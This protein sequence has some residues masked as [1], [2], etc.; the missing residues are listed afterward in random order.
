[1]EKIYNEL[2]EV[3][4]TKESYGTLAGSWCQIIFKDN[5]GCWY[6]TPFSDWGDMGCI[7]FAPDGVYNPKNRIS[8]WEY[9]QSDKNVYNTHLARAQEFEI[10]QDC[11][12]LI[13]YLELMKAI[14]INV[15]SDYI[16]EMI[17]AIEGCKN[18]L[19][20]YIVEKDFTDIYFLLGICDT[21]QYDW[22][23]NDLPELY[24]NRRYH[25]LLDDIRNDY[26]D[27]LYDED[28]Y[29]Y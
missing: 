12:T 21:I 26:I 13:K 16:D 18:D 15:D 20:K 5:K 7:F 22:C 27:S 4:K 11:V 2:L 6:K 9:I 25:L 23:R 19:K 10:Y 8:L 28:N 29:I 17:I 24:I 1:M 14:N 3:C